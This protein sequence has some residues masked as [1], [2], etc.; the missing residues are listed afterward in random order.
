MAEKMKL[1]NNSEA[2]CYTHVLPVIDT[3]YKVTVSVT[4][5]LREFLQQRQLHRKTIS[6][7]ARANKAPFGCEQTRLPPS[8]LPALLH[9][10][11]N[12]RKRLLRV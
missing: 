4:V 7:R 3:W 5:L 2:V 12:T 8:C 11:E 6:A 10:H 9:Q 1:I